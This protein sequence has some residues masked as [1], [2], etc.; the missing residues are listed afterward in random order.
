M[1]TT[2]P[3]IMSFILAVLTLIFIIYK[4][5]NNIWAASLAGLLVNIISSPIFVF[6]I[7]MLDNAK[8]LPLLYRTKLLL[9]NQDVRISI[10]YLFR[11]KVKDHYLL[12]KNRTGNYYQLVGGAYKR[13][14]T[15]ENIFK[16]YKIKSDK[17]FCTDDGI[18]KNDLRF[19]VPGK[20][21]LD[22]IKWF[23][24]KEDRE[25]SQ[26]REFCEELLSTN[27]L[28]KR[29]FRYIDYTYA[30]TLQ[31]PIQKAKYLDCQEILIYEIYDL[32]PNEE[33]RIVL[34][35]LFNKGNT[36]QVKWASEP[37]INGLGFNEYKKEKEF[38][39]GAHTKWAIQLKY[40]NE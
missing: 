23:Q 22:I 35:E 5:P 18:A 20:Y 27:I 17:Q 16:K 26:W 34:E 14:Q 36:E 39:I 7:L 11:I 1:K 10:A 15:S 29:T 8:Q 12:V 33:Q 19:R 21:V 9:R 30:G 37:L 24:S 38:D 2:L 25:T 31:T 28:C 32:L 13:Y 4:Y 6:I 40:T 3:K